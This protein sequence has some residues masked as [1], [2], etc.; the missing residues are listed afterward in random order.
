MAVR[1][2]RLRYAGVCAVCQHPLEAGTEV[3][4]HTDRKTAVCAACAADSTAAVH[5][6]TGGGS[7]RAEAA[8]RRNQQRARH[9]RT[10][11]AHPVLGRLALAVT[12]EA[13]AGATWEKGA[14]GEERLSHWLDALPGGTTLSLHDRRLPRSKANIDHI[15]ITANGVWVIDAKHYKG[16]VEKRDVGGWLRTDRRL[17]VGG[18]DRSSLVTGVAAQVEHVRRSLSDLPGSV[19]A[20]RGMLFFVKADWRLFTRPFEL[21]SVVVAWP[22]PV[23]RRLLADGPVDATQ[24][25][26]IQRH[27]AI[28]LPPP[29]SA[30]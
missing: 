28:S 3:D 27:L 30:P 23:R 4:W 22:R 7:A 29:S 5:S 10:K 15:V 16:V 8:R 6:G 14:V 9:E 11:Q 12:P 13:D 26:E 17:F 24:R 19:P 2:L 18:R 21:Q 25:S 1:Q 20:V